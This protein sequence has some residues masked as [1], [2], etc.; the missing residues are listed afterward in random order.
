VLTDL[1]ACADGTIGSAIAGIVAYIEGCLPE[2][3]ALA[4]RELVHDKDTI[5]PFESLMEIAEWL[6]EVFTGRPTTPSSS[7]PPG[8]TSTGAASEGGSS[9]PATAAPAL[10]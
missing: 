10:V 3:D 4:F 2:A 9:L 8:S 6:V 1:I 5:V 7:S